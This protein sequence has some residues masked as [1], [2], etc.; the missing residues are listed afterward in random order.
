MCSCCLWIKASRSVPW[1]PRSRP[2]AQNSSSLSVTVVITRELTLASSLFESST[3]I[4]SIPP[5][6]RR[7]HL[8]CP[9]Q[10]QYA[11]QA[12]ALK[13]PASTTMNPH[14]YFPLNSFAH[15]RILDFEEQIDSLEHDASITDQCLNILITREA[16]QAPPNPRARQANPPTPPRRTTIPRDGEHA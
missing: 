8:H 6:Q 1:S 12:F 9:N 5:Y 11:T 10:H 7:S 2:R 4:S 14:L 15:A 16:N 13:H 3:S